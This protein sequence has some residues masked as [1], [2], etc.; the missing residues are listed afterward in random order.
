VKGASRFDIPFAHV[1]NLTGSMRTTRLLLVEPDPLTRAALGAAGARSARVD[2]CSS[3]HSARA[4]LN[5]TAYDLIVTAARL[6]EYNGIHLVYIARNAHQPTNA[7]VYDEQIDPGFAAEVLR[8]RA[9]YEIAQR[10]PVSLSAYIDASLPMTDR[11]TPA[12]AD[13]RLRPRGGRRKWD[14][15]IS[16]FSLDETAR[17]PSVDEG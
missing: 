1:R 13:R 5:A 4:R 16:R 6:R 8:A 9:F 17:A 15:H 2:A 14:R 7:I 11:R 10:L 12:I 3:F